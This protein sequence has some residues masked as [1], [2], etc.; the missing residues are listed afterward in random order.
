MVQ[1]FERK[2]TKRLFGALDPLAGVRLGECNSKVFAHCLCL[3]GFGWW[4][5][6]YV[7]SFGEGVKEFDAVAEIGVVNSRLETEAVLDGTGE[8]VEKVKSSSV[9]CIS[10]VDLAVE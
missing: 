9:I 7:G 5:D 6:V 3:A 8:C 4:W 2:V 1:D 10:P